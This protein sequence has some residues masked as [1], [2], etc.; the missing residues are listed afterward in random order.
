[1]ILEVAFAFGVCIMCFV[2]AVGHISGGHFNPA[3][4]FST[5]LWGQMNPI[6]GV[7]YIVVQVWKF[8]HASFERIFETP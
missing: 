4:T 7:M 3:V 8:W 2:Y 6:K 1:M 5:V